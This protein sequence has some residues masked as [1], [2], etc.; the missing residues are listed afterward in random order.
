MVGY[1]GRG[2]SGWLSLA[3]A[4]ALNIWA[5]IRKAEG[6][7]SLAIEFLEGAKELNMAVNEHIWNGSWYSRGI[8]DDGISFGVPDDVEGR[9]FLNPQGWAILSGAADAERSS[10]IIKAVEE[11]L[12]TP[13][14]VEMLSPSFTS[15]REDVGRVTQKHPGSA[16]N[17]SVYNHAAAFYIYALFCAD[18][19]NKAYELLSRMIPGPEEKDLLRRGQLPVFIP[20]YYR[21]AFRQFER[22]AGR[23][24]QLFNTGTVSWIYRSLIDGLFGLKGERGGLRVNP[25]LPDAW[26]EARVIR[27]FRGAELHIDIQKQEIQGRLQVFLN[28][29]LLPDNLISGLVS[30]KVYKVE[31]K[32]PA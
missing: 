4:Y 9:I 12:E 13:Y 8:T 19:G 5:E 22:T 29:V 23:S 32:V 17:G 10:K 27:K 11:E 14:G 20:N 15:M 2:V 1:K 16:E 24:S 3:S 31:V 25:F 7:E 6:K 28:D 26:D 18:K 30:G 21:G